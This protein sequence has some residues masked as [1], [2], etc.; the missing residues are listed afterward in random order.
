LATSGLALQVP[1]AVIL[2]AIFKDP[3]WLHSLSSGI[4]TLLGGCI[5]L[6]GFI[7]LNRT[8][9]DTSGQSRDEDQIPLTR[10]S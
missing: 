8:E 2:D 4:L 3:G 7:G 10:P 9:E 5:I 6:V 1:I